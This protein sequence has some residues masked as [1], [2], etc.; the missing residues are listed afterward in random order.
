MG[1][2]VNLLCIIVLGASLLFLK[3]LRHYKWIDANYT[4]LSRIVWI[5]YL[6]AI[7]FFILPMY[8]MDPNPDW[9]QRNNP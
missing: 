2:L 1:I 7:F 4:L 9:R 5:L 3:S 8:N 6:L